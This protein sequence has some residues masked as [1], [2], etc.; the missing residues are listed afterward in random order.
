MEGGK[1][2]L[3]TGFGA[4]FSFSGVEKP[5][6]Q[7]L[8][9]FLEFLG[10]IAVAAGPGLRPFGVAAVFAGVRVLDAKEVEVFFPIRPFFLEGSGAETD[11]NPGADAVWADAG[12]VHVVEVFIA[13]DR[14]AAEGA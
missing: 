11:F 8:E 4:D 6:A 10:A 14:A 3:A 5:L 9:A 2:H 13:R 1:W 12:L 7:E